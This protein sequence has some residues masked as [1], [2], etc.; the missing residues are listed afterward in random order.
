MASISGAFSPSSTLLRP[1]R[2]Q[3]VVIST[4]PLRRL[5]PLQ[6]IADLPR[7]SSP[8]YPSSSS[9]NSAKSG[10][11]SPVEKDPI[12]LWNRYVDW[13]Y[14]HKE[15]GLFLD[16]SRI[17]F[18]DE[19]L[20]KMEPKMQKAFKAMEEL[21]KGAISNP[22][23]KR[24]VGHYWLRSPHL[25]PNRVLKDQIEKMLDRICEFAEAIISAKVFNVSFYN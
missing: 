22:D 8:S 12:K 21:E 25:A 19:F 16:V 15:L 23:E 11:I 13:L 17:G 1:R 6:S 2:R 18:S 20:R 9:N 5:R 10:P 4:C 3:S 14:Q 7:S 24:M